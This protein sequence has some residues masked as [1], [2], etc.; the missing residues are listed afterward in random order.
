[1]KKILPLTSLALHTTFCSI[2]IR[3]R[4]L[5]EL[6]LH[7]TRLVPLTNGLVKLAIAGRGHCIW[8]WDWKRNHWRHCLRVS[9]VLG[10]GS[11]ACMK[12]I[13]PLTSLGLHTTS[14]ALQRMCP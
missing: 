8:S 2:A 3:I 13:L 4:G 5:L 14:L 11:D 9:H 10:L 12:K 7:D 1:M 6:G